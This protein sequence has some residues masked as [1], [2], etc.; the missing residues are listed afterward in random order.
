MVSPKAPA[1]REIV[2]RRDLAP[3]TVL[4]IASLGAGLAFVDATIVNVAF[5]DIRA[6]FQGSTLS[7]VSWVLNT[8]N[9]IFAAFLV[10]AGRVADLLGRKR[11]FEAGIVLFTVA[12]LLCAAAP[13][14]GLLVAARVLQALGAAILVPASLALVLHA[15]AGEQRTHGV[16]LWSAS[17]A[18]AA[19]LGPSLGGV[20]VDLG[21]WR[22]AFL[23]N[24][25]IGAAALLASKRTLVESRAPGRRSVPDLL[26]ALLLAG[27][28]SALT[29]GIVKGEDWGWAAPA[30]I[31]SFAA[32]LAI[33]AA[34][35]RRCTWHSS[36]MID[37]ALLRVRSLAVANALSIV[38]AAGFYAYVLCN[39]LFLT[40]V[41][42]YSVLQAGLAIT[43]GPF[44]A[45]AVAGP[46]SRAAARIGPRAVLA[47]G[48]TVWAA[49]VGYLVRAVGVEP[50]F[51]GEWLPGMLLLGLGAGLTF[52]VAGATAVAEV[53]GG[54]FATATGLNSVSR[55][56]GA[57]LG[58]ALLVAIVGMPEPVQLAAAFDRG[59]TFAGVCFLA[60]AAGA[61]AL[62]PVRPAEHAGPPAPRRTEP[63][64]IKRPAPTQ[65]GRGAHAASPPQEPLTPPELL[66]KAPLFSGLGDAVLRQLADRANLVSIRAG[67]WLLRQGDPARSVY[68][69]ASGRLDV[70]L[71]GAE[72]EL[73]WSV[74]SGEVIGDL[75]L[76]AGSAHSA[77]V[78]ARRD[79]ALLELGAEEFDA[80]VSTQPQFGRDLLRRM[81]RQLQRSRALAGSGPS[82]QSTLAL[83][84]LHRDLPVREVADGL[85]RELSAAGPTTLFDAPSCQGEAEEATRLERYERHRDHVLL[86]AEDPGS[87]W[88]AFCLRHADRVIA[89]ASDAPLPDWAAAAT[90]IQGCDLV[91]DTAQRERPFADLSALRPRARHRLERGPARAESLARAG[92]RIAGQAV[93]FVLS[94]GGARAFAHIG[95]LDELLRAGITID[96]VGGCSMGAWIGGLLA[97]GMEPEEIDARCYEEW[98]RRRPF[99]YRLSRESLLRGERGRRALERNFP[100]NIDGLP[101]D[102]FA[103][104]ADLVTRE[105]VVH[106][107]GPLFE[108]VGASMALPGFV[109]PL[110]LDGKLLVDGGVLNN[111]PV[112]VMAATGE[113]PVIATDVTGRFEP[114]LGPDSPKPGLGET[115]TRALLLGSRD[116]AKLARSHADLVIAPDSD[117]VGLLEWHQ[118]DRLRE[119]GRRAAADALADAPP[120]LFP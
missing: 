88:G 74:S 120:S 24:L 99:D 19:G 93:G 75:A 80:L 68:V 51:V 39:I 60:V 62:G 72:G 119:A 10:A 17:A 18:L 2:T 92:R 95:A 113:G 87:A 32:S 118:L 78:R 71:A 43:P 110:A 20:L 45:A 84:P 55:Q 31:A 115:I 111:L 96:R 6:D 56:L 37:L 27:S 22:L 34:F 52:P 97:Q 13:S 102:F 103:V 107:R 108:A 81:G 30:T 94:G 85:F 7:S 28:I 12:S 11:L 46:A 89:L 9:I 86:L 109:S 83:V 69:V 25:P 114:P 38:G 91:L 35:A 59:W 65:I 21:G 104:S 73:L 77:S 53:P 101:L 63:P 90:G 64:R 66:A 29:L 33:G 42:D 67:D 98:V 14:V 40:A 54:R 61:L 3:R 47:I 57:V 58:V 116:T 106:S 26:G 112:D 36:P 4:T 48:G 16:A 79:A 1:E 41:W 50:D 100:G 82:P 70:V 76:M 8:Y 49:G 15:F 117:G 23:V 105:Q 44:V 5:P